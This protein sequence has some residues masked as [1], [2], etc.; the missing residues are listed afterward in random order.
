MTAAQLAR[1]FEPFNRLGREHSAIEGTGIGLTL[2]KRMLEQ[3]GGHIAVASEVGIGT[4]LSLVLPTL[5]PTL[6]PTL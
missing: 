6:Q 4:R 1:M 5:Q 3:M 2:S